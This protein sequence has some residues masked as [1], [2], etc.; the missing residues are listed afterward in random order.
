MYVWVFEAGV[1]TGTGAGAGITVE[2]G[3]G[4]DATL[5][6]DDWT[7]TA[8]S[9]NEDKDGLTPGDLSNDE[10]ACTGSAPSIAGAYD[11]A[12]QAS[13]DGGPWL[14]CDLAGD[15]GSGSDDGYSVDTAGSLTVE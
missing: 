8:C 14:S 13:I 2:L 5:P 11:F 15:F 4:A 9:F 3:V 1:T 6:G 7:W 12:G 10:Y